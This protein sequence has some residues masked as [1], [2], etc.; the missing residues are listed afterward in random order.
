MREKQSEERRKRERKERWRERES[1]G[2][3]EREGGRGRERAREVQVIVSHE[4]IGRL[5][6][7]AARS[8]WVSPVL[9]SLLGFEV[10]RKQG[11]VEGGDVWAGGE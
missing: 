5:M 6:L 1:D 7:L 3:G 10:T 4:L 2:E 11:G 9:S 8:P